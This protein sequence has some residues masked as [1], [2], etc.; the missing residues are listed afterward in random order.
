MSLTADQRRAPRL[1]AQEAHGVTEALM[2][3]HG[4]RRA[5]LAGLVLAGL[6][7]VTTDTMRAGAATGKVERYRITEIGRNA[8]A[9]EG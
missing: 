6:A 9:A 4:F 3:A 8:L 5:M 2:L 1:L 7:R